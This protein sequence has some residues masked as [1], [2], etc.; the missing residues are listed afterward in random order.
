MGTNLSTPS[1]KGKNLAAVVEMVLPSYFT[2]EAITVRLRLVPVPSSFAAT[3]SFVRSFTRSLVSL[4]RSLLYTLF[5]LVSCC[6]NNSTPTH[7]SLLITSSFLQQ[8]L[9][10]LPS[11][12][13]VLGHCTISRRRTSRW[14]QNLGPGSLTIHRRVTRTGST[15]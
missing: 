5:F 13:L 3:H 14:C 15:T 9:L 7:S 10:V 12:P 1:S 2:K 8:Q 6:S 11:L 4:V